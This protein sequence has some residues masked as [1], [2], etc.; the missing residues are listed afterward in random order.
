MINVD[1]IKVG[2]IVEIE[3]GMSIPCDAIVVNGTGITTDESAMTGESIELKKE[4][5]EM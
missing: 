4:G 3:V 5:I 1:E 2:D